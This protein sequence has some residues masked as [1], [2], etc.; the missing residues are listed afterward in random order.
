[1]T[2]NKWLGLLP[3]V[4]YATEVTLNTSLYN[5]HEPLILLNPLQTVPEFYK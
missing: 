4:W 2:K 5:K 1:M 3:A